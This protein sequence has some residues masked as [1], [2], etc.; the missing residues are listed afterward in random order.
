M[1]TSEWSIE[2]GQFVIRSQ[3]PSADVHCFFGDNRESLNTLSDW[4]AALRKDFPENTLTEHQS[5]IEKKTG[6]TFSV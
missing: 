2:N 6:I 1:R 3:I 4:E 5:A